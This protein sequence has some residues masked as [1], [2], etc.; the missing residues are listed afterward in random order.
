MGAIPYGYRWHQGKVQYN[1]DWVE[2]DSKLPADLHTCNILTDLAN[3]INNSIQFTGDVP[4][5]Y[6]SKR[7]PMLDMQMKIIYLTSP[8]DPATNTPEYTYPQISYTFFKKTMARK[9][10]MQNNSAMPE[11]IK[12]ETITNEALRR[13]SNITQG[14]PD[15]RANTVTA[16]NEYM[17]SLIHI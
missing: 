7:V 10:I 14:H 13:L 3:S 15:T 4:S 2:E 6:S 12:R 9:S 5:N 8:E 1:K 16:L 17:L 11:G